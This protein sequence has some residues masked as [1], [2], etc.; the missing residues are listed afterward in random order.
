[1]ASGILNTTRGLGTSLGVA[2]TGV[3]FG[4]AAGTT[5]AHT[6]SSGLVTRGFSAASLFLLVMALLAALLALLAGPRPV[7]ADQTPPV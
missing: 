3:V 6:V 2:L 5:A 7:A 4:L 1:M